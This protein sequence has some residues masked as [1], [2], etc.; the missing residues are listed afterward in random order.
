MDSVSGLQRFQ[1]GMQGGKPVDAQARF[2]EISQ[3]Q[4]QPARMALQPPANPP[5]MFASLIGALTRPSPQEV[6]QQG[7]ALDSL[8]N[9]LTKA[10][11]Q[12][13]MRLATPLLK[14][15]VTVGDAGHAIAS[16]RALHCAA[17]DNLQV[18]TERIRTGMTLAG[19]V[20]ADATCRLLARI[21]LGADLYT[22]DLSASRAKA[23]A[24][25]GLDLL[26]Q[27]RATPGMSEPRALQILR[28]AAA[29][30]RTASASQVALE[31]AA[32][33]AKAA[34][35]SFGGVAY[36]HAAVVAG[37]S[38]TAHVPQDFSARGTTTPSQ[39]QA[40]ILSGQALDS[41]SETAQSLP[42][43]HAQMARE[44]ASLQTNEKMHKATAADGKTFEV[45]DLAMRDAPRSDITVRG[46][47]LDRA[48]DDF[49][50][51]LRDALPAGDKG[52]ALARIISACANQ[53]HLVGVENYTADKTY[54]PMGTRASSFCQEINRR[55]DGL[56]SVRGTFH[57]VTSGYTDLRSGADYVEFNE[58]ATTLYSVEFLIDP[59]QDDEAPRLA[60][61]ATDVAFTAGPRGT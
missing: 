49:A 24:E 17:T 3:G 39:W 59:G 35:P 16:A 26:A 13:V 27:L 55:E 12:E 32:T 6:Q 31:L 53:R 37:A 34:R 33:D 50:L 45:S 15:H 22:E 42:D 11:G 18:M 4:G 10:Y 14:G 58:P 20:P 36:G 8:R 38:I 60:S 51:A 61:I 44:V 5:G 40:D 54:S 47:T 56:W 48:R 2:V 41:R 30:P 19:Q 7:A 21:G 29:S 9:D 46:R 57:R 1:V 28:F 43:L 23:A 52:N 25:K